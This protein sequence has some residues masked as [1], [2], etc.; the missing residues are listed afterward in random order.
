M[1]HGKIL[2]ATGFLLGLN[3]ITTQAA[4]ISNAHAEFNW[5]NLSVYVNDQLVS[6]SEYTL[7]TPSLKPGA[8]SFA[9]PYPWPASLSYTNNLEYSQSTIG[10]TTA[11][12]GSGNTLQYATSTA[13]NGIAGSMTRQREDR[14]IIFNASGSYQIVVPYSL[15][16]DI[17]GNAV[18]GEISYSQAG[19]NLSIGYG[20][21]GQD[22]G[23]AERWS[24][25]LQFLNGAPELVTTHCVFDT[26]CNSNTNGIHTSSA[27]TVNGLLSFNLT[28]QQFI[29]LG[30]V[31]TSASN[32]IAPPSA[33]PV[34]GAVWL[35]SSA[36]LGF[37]GLNRRSS[38]VA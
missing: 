8:Y 7:T 31:N 1:K 23:S 37:V 32:F 35:F 36:I 2:L 26:Q 22:G 9:N 25:L 4:Q 11:V 12:A 5:D 13:Q 14:S 17:S 18:P 24:A 20:G 34:P 30:G 38:L 6:K 28:G 33:V 15:S 16:I 21:L 3:T 19:L 29:F 10:V 27:P